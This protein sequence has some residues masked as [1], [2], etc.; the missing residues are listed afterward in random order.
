MAKHVDRHLSVDD[1]HLELAEPRRIAD[2]LD[3]LFFVIKRR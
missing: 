2:N 3:V 1:R